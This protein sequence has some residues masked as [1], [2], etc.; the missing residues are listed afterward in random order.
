LGRPTGERVQSDA[1]DNS[2]IFERLTFRR[3]QILRL[4]ADG[5][6]EPEAARLLGIE[7]STVHSPVDELRDLTG[8]PSGREMG[9]WWREV[10][11]DWIL[12]AAE[13]GGLERLPVD[14]P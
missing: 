13:T 10:R 2:Y 1:A 9:R 14:N 8:L 12:W 11:D 3:L 7:P 6:T 5:R 4:L